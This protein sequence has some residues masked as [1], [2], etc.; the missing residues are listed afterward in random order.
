[1]CQLVELWL[2]VRPLALQFTLGICL[3]VY[4]WKLSQRSANHLG[5]ISNG[6]HLQLQTDFTR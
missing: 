1:M 3:P 5:G 6:G 2:V 4:P